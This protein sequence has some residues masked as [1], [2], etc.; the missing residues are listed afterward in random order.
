MSLIDWKYMFC[1]LR[2]F[3][4]FPGGLK[5]C[6]FAV[7]AES[8]GINLPPCY[9]FL[10]QIECSGCWKIICL[11]FD[12]PIVHLSCYWSGKAKN[13]WNELCIPISE[14][15]TSHI[16]RLK[17]TRNKGDRK[18]CVFLIERRVRTQ[19][20]IFWVSSG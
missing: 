14:I 16:Y 7:E 4:I 13:N 10:V 1:I 20:Y 3:S 18:L 12:A 5:P 19:C 6:R 17:K 8:M 15:A 9:Y 2:Q 11:I